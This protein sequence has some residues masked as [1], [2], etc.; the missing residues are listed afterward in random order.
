[1]RL[2]EKK[3]KGK[4]NGSLL[5]VEDAWVQHNEDRDGFGSGERR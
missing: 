4:V 2:R 1:M 5:K 3:K